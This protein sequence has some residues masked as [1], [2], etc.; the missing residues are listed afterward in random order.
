MHIKVEVKMASLSVEIHI[1]KSLT[2]VIKMT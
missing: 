2:L 1:N